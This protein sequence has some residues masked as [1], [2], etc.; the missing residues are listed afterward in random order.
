MKSL[1][2]HFPIFKE[3]NRVYFDSAA[4]SFKPQTVIDLLH[5]HMTTQSVSVHRGVYKE[6][7]LMT[8]QFENVRKST[9]QML[10]AQRPEEI[11][12]TRGAT[13]GI[14]IIAHSYGSFL[15]EGDE[16]V[17]TMME[18]HSNI[19]PWQMLCNLKKARLTVVPIIDA[20]AHSIQTLK[21][22]IT[23][24][25][26]IVS[27]THMSNLTGV[28]LPLKEIASHVHA[29]GAVLVVDGA[30]GIVH[31]R[32][33][34]QDTDVDFYVFSGHKMYGPTG[35][36]ILYGKYH[37]LEAMPPY[38]GGGNMIEEVTM[39]HTSY[40]SSPLK[41]EAGTASIGPVIALKGA[42]DFYQQHYEQIY[43]HTQALSK[44]LRTSLES[45]E[46]IKIFTPKEVNSP[47]V[48]FNIEGV[49]PLDM[50]MFLSCEGFCIRSGHQC[51]QPFVRF[52]GQEHVLRASLACY[53]TE[54]EIERFTKALNKGIEQLRC[55]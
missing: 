34:V 35:V 24:R 7:A 31:S 54:E 44:H 1:R 41:F 33:D 29:Q 25:T 11:I 45:I 46:G 43:S 50:A 4:T 28:T 16:V 40:Q 9:Q 19:V 48:S 3:Y 22:A 18:H 26:K 47:I 32:I 17:I 8:E 42:I 12:F 37:L 30:Q 21:Q 13:D 15:R 2:E 23:S 6:V 52:L 53:N 39:E 55:L 27:I 49:H 38:Q 5:K 36:G 10:N 51:A 20:S 14:N